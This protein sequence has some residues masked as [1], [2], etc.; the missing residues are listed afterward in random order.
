MNLNRTK[1]TIVC[2]LFALSAPFSKSAEFAYVLVDDSFQQL[3]SNPAYWNLENGVDD[4]AA[5]YPDGEDTFTID[6]SGTISASTRLAIEGGPPFEVGGIVGKGGPNRDI[7]LKFGVFTLGDLEVQE[8]AN[9]FF[10]QSERDKDFDI[11]GVVSGA[12]DLELHR[13]GGFSDGV[14]EGEETSFKGTEPNTISGSIRLYNS[15]GASQPAYWVA[16]KVGAFGQASQL[17]VEGRFGLSGVSSLRIT[18]NTVGGEGAIDDDATTVF[19]GAEGL[20][21]LEAGVDEKIGEGNLFLDLEGTGTYTEVAPGVYN[22]AEPWI[23]GD[24][25]VTVGAFSALAVTEIEYLTGGVN[26][27]V[28]LTWTSSP[29]QLYV[30]KYS[31]DMIDWDSDLDDGVVGDEGGTTTREFDLTHFPGL[32]DEERVYFRIELGS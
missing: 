2:S 11:T 20:L 15:S 29:G 25:T 12:G 7:V 31:T 3:W 27:S 8:S 28:S 16:D 6:R 1:P 10:I 9:S 17:T 13:L 24:G 19:I 14:Q 21:V 32:V 23:E 22:N 18:P 4:G 30:V 26:P 5:G